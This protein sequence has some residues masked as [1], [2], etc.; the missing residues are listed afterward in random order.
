MS[1]KKGEHHEKI[2]ITEE[3]NQITPS[4]RA[5]KWQKGKKITQ[6]WVEFPL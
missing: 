1:V 3:I 5:I 4:P 6:L 2:A